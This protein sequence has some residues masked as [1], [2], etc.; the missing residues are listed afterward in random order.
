MKIP[1]ADR[2]SG[3]LD[4]YSRDSIATHSK[5]V[6]QRKKECFFLRRKGWLWLMRVLVGV[7]VNCDPQGGN[8]GGDDAP[9]PTSRSSTGTNWARTARRGL[10]FK[11][12]YDIRQSVSTI[13][14]QTIRASLSVASLARAK[15]FSPKVQPHRAKLH[16]G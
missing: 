8:D 2:G 7:A 5:D 1:S 3:W 10:R 4:A 12:G 14:F 9:Q 16:P 11:M 15:D 6:I 13:A